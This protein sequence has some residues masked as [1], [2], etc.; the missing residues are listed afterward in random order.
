MLT[1][2]TRPHSHAH[3]RLKA[4]CEKGCVAQYHKSCWQEVVKGAT[5]HGGHAL[6][7]QC[8]AHI[9][10]TSLRINFGE[11]KKLY[12]QGD[13]SVVDPPDH[14][15]STTTTAAATKNESEE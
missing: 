3:T 7:A 6:C 5:P 1:S 8:G 13:E 2:R 9:A 10:W 4:K 14:G 11:K 12:A 15:T